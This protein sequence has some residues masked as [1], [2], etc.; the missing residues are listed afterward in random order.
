MAAP[1]ARREVPPAQALDLAAAAFALL[2]SPM[3]LH[4]V[5]ALAQQEND[6][7]Q[8]ARRVGG[9]PQAVS[10]HLAKL[11]LAGVA[12]AR[13]QGRHHVY[14]VSD[15]HL[16]TAAQHMLERLTRDVAKVTIRA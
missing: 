10:Q 5:W 7:S 3:R 8:L 11:K 14:S 2:S 12:H 4:I 9:T 15:Q 1:A 13:R 16:T 6:V